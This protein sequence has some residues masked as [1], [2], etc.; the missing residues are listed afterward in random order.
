VADGG[1]GPCIRDMSYT[2][3]VQAQQTITTGSRVDY[4]ASANISRELTPCIEISSTSQQHEQISKRGDTY[5]P[6][7]CPPTSTAFD[8][9]TISAPVCG[10][11]P[12]YR[13]VV[14]LLHTVQAAPPL[15]HSRYLRMETWN[16]HR[17]FGLSTFATTANLKPPPLREYQGSLSPRRIL[18]NSTTSMLWKRART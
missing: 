1:R 12:H 10:L 18:Q 2:L 8:L 11:Y 6:T 9:S 13:H 4:E 3:E 15:P 7:L 14:G 16:T 17:S 5:I